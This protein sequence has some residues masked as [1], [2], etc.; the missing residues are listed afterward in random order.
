MVEEHVEVEEIDG[1]G[2]T[3]SAKWW[4]ATGNESEAHIVA[5]TAEEMKLVR[6]KVGS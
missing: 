2:F 3:W 6:S 4:S 1:H 5:L